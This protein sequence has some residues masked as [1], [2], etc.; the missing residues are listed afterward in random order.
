MA[1]IKVEPAADFRPFGGIPGLGLLGSIQQPVQASQKATPSGGHTTEE[2]KEPHEILPHSLL[3]LHSNGLIDEARPNPNTEAETTNGER[4][5]DSAIKQGA[6][7]HLAYARAVFAESQQQR[8]AQPSAPAVSLEHAEE[9]INDRTIPEIAKGENITEAEAA[10][11]AS[12][13]LPSSVTTVA[14]RELPGKS[15]AAPE[16]LQTVDTPVIVDESPRSLHESAPVSDPAVSTAGI[17][18]AAESH[19]I[20][21]DFLK[22]GEANKSDAN[23]EWQLDSSDDSSDSSS[24]LSSESSSDDEDDDEDEAQLLTAEEQARILM[25]EDYDEDGGGHGQEIP[26][27]KNE[28]VQLKFEKPD[29]IV[30]PDM[31]VVELGHVEQISHDVSLVPTSSLFLFARTLMVILDPVAFPQTVLVP[32]PFDEILRRRAQI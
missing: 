7:S 8:P 19:N 11:G 21:E 31:K 12:G 5:H 6:A 2:T 14:E 4:S 17:P 20:D 27:T 22:A 1:P 32:P 13:S 29:V 26:R 3:S 30:T 18:T 16:A 28:V 23:A 24:D 15:V 9:E 10:V 25:A